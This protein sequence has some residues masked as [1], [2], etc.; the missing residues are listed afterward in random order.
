TK[1]LLIG[2]AETYD[3]LVTVPSS[4]AWEFRSIAHDGSGHT[5][6]WIGK[7]ERHPA[8]DMPMPFLYDT[9]DMFGFPELFALTPG[10]SMGMPGHR[11]KAGD[12]DQ[13]GMNMEMHT[14]KK[15][16]RDDGGTT[17]G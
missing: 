4:G 14:M 15:D 6:L 2:V 11:V 8:P 13:P 16:R 10:G 17:A 12:F 9:M 7:G 3:V 5:S 1:P